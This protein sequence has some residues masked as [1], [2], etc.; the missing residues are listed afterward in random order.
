ML[1]NAIR[2]SVHFS[3]DFVD[4]VHKDSHMSTNTHTQRNTYTYTYPH[5]HTYTQT[6]PLWGHMF[7]VFIFTRSDSLDRLAIHAGTRVYICDILK[8]TISTKYASNLTKWEKIK[9]SG[10]SGVW[11]INLQNYYLSGVMVWAPATQCATIVLALIYFWFQ[12]I[13]P[14]YYRRKDQSPIYQLIFSL[15][16]LM[17]FWL[18]LQKSSRIPWRSDLSNGGRRGRRC[19]L[20]GFPHDVVKVSRHHCCW[21]VIIVV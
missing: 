15:K 16:Y 3:L 9:E 10:Y 5:T 21:Y 13:S 18:R 6:N 4:S 17:G 1:S 11:I 14:S 2:I 7:W 19:Y 20:L 12:V 8:I